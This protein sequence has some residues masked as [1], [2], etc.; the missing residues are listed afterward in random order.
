MFE[1]CRAHFQVQDRSPAARAGGGAVI[2]FQTARWVLG[3][4]YR[5]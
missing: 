5:L 3:N 1:S 4:E 2:V